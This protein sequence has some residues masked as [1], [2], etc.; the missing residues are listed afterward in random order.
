MTG[1]AGDAVVR[2]LSIDKTITHWGTWSETQFSFSF[3]HFF[4]TIVL[5]EDGIELTTSH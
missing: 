5:A 3:K 4:L 2:A 1:M